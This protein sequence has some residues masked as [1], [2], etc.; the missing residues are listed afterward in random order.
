MRTKGRTWLYPSMWTCQRG[1]ASPTMKTTFQVPKIETFTEISSYKQWCG[2]G[3]FIPDPDFYPSRIP[4]CHTI[5]CSHKF[6]KIENCFSFEML[7]TKIWAN[8]L[9]ILKK[10][11]EALKYMGLGSGIRKKPIPD[12]GSRGQKAT[13]PRIRIHNTRYKPFL[14]PKRS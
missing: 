12:P 13:G 9:R 1:P 14:C 6:H 4:D 3:M 2:S 10:C 5:L 7:K 11:H 8:F